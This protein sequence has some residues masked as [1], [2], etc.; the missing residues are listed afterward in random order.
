MASGVRLG[1]TDFPSN[2]RYDHGVELLE[3]NGT[4]SALTLNGTS[5]HTSFEAGQKLSP[6][7]IQADSVNLGNY[8]QVQNVSFGS[9]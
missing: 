6:I 7:V 4:D 3:I 1:C 5:F 9:N 2:S 8:V